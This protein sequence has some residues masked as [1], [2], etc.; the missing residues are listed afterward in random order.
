MSTFEDYLTVEEVL[1]HVRRSDALLLPFRLVPS[2]LPMSIL[3]AMALGKPVVSTDVDGIPE[4]LE[5]GRGIVIPPS[6][7][8]AL[9]GAMTRLIENPGYGEELG[10]RARTYVSDRYSESEGLSDLR[11]LIRAVLDT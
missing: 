9:T 5:D 2:D 8:S 1:E 11:Q 7:L 3:E 6:N 10:A 4:F